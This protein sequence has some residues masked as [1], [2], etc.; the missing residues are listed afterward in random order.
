MA[1][2]MKT[3]GQNWKKGR[4]P[5]SPGRPP[6]S[7]EAKRL[8][9]Y[10][11][12]YLDKGSAVE[13]FDKF[14]KQD[15]G[16]ALRFAADRIWGRPQESEAR[17]L[18]VNLPDLPRSTPLPQENHRVAEILQILSECGAIP[19]PVQLEKPPLESPD[20]PSA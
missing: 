4:A 6:A 13:D 15:P 2:G 16:A 1:K 12:V 10:L 17:E 14:R 11:T 9:N 19:G 20:P 3:G 5:K 18:T 7:E 8:K